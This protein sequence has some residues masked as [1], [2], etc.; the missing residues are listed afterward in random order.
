M[1][2]T[3]LLISENIILDTKIVSLCSLDMTFECKTCI[4]TAIL[5]AILKIQDGHH[6]K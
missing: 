5:A 4:L 6:Q 3:E 1:V 2:T